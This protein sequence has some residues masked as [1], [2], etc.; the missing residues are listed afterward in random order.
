MSELVHSPPVPASLLRS[1]IELGKPRITTLVVFTAAIGRLLA[2]LPPDPFAAAAFLAGTALLVASANTLN[3]WLERDSDARMVRTRDRALPAGRIEPA[4]ALALG[5]A[6]GVAALALLALA[7]NPLVVFLGALAH[8][9]YVLAYTPL[10]RVSP[11]SLL[12]GAI[13]GA[14]P[15]LMGWASA[16][17]SLAAPGWTLFG[18][19]FFWQIPHFIAVALY[20]EEDYRRGGL[21]VLSVASGGTATRLHLLAG[22]AALVAVSLLAVPLGMAGPAYLVAACLLG[23]A[24]LGFAVRGLRRSAGGAWARRTFLYSIVYLTLLVTCLLLD[25]K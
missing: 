20:L 5:A 10:K 24:F 19:L 1:A 8:L 22:T 25:A 4:A 11:V 2:P 23:G 17:G 21:R 7:S 9:T 18:I 6:E 15:P 16:T 14:I 13:P 3:C 12:V